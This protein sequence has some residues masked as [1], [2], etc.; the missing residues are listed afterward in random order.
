MKNYF[1]LMQ[2][3]FESVALCLIGGVIGLLLVWGVISLLGNVVDFNFILPLSR[4]AMGMSIS[5]VVGLVAGIVPAMKAA[6]L[7][8]VDAMRSK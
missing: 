8:P 2:F 5:I 3:L 1:I 4:I 7:N 6:N